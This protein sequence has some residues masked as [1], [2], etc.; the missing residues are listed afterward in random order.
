M[1]D[2]ALIN[3]SCMLLCGGGG[4][5]GGWGGGCVWK[6]LT[7]M[8]GLC[9]SRNEKSQAVGDLSCLQLL[10]TMTHSSGMC[11]AQTTEVK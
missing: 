11:L 3:P 10:W 5:G 7:I 6:T 2:S 8:I 1:G 9:C 4:G